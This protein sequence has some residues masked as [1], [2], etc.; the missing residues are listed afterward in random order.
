MIPG[1]KLTVFEIHRE[2]F[3]HHYLDNIERSPDPAQ[4]IRT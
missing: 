2:L 3:Y 1:K 4:L